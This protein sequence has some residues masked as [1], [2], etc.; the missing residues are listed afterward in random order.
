MPIELTPSV[1]AYS[2]LY[3]YT[4]NYLDDPGISSKS[5]MEFNSCLSKRLTGVS[6]EPEN[7]HEQIVYDLI[8]MIEIQFPRGSNPQVYESLLA[9]HSAQIKSLL[10]L[11]S[12]TNIEDDDLLNISIEK[13]GTSVLADGYLIAGNLTE[14]Q[15]R[16]LFGY[17]AYLQLV[18][19]MQDAI[20]D[21]QNGFNTIFSNQNKCSYL[22]SIANQLFHFGNLVLDDCY[23]LEII[24]ADSIINLM[25]RTNELLII[26]SVGVTKDCYSPD[27]SRQMEIYSPFSFPFLQQ[28][29]NN[30]FQLGIMV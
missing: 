4:D 21:R 8:G 14:E 26:N 20:S 11:N 12:N 5:K 29:Q 15:K 10:L 23:S 9:I 7:K 3:P 18:D 19:D 2:L 13:G 16:F 24:N 30:Y 17:G 22:E 27:F 1:F 25:K 6:I 28:K